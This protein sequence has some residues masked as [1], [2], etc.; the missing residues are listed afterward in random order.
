[1]RLTPV[2]DLINEW[3]KRWAGGSSAPFAHPGPR[4]ISTQ[5]ILGPDHPG[6]ALEFL[7][8]QRSRKAVLKSPLS[9][10]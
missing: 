7:R 1:M 5:E 8:A 10:R 9:K 4:L 6:D 2:F 3:N